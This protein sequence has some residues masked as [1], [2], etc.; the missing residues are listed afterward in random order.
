MATQ[1]CT[2]LTPYPRV[3]VTKITWTRGK[4]RYSVF[5]VC[6]VFTGP[7]GLQSAWCAFW[8]VRYFYN[9]VECLIKQAGSYK[10]SSETSLF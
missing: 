5:T 7:H 9:D 10:Q 1:E 3:H 6:T 2:E 8:S 4:K